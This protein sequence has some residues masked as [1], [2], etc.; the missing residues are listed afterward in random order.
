MNDS[1]LESSV[2]G[3]ESK[4]PSPRASSVFS[5][6][7]DKLA[8]TPVKISHGYNLL[9]H[10]REATDNITLNNLRVL[11][12]LNFAP[13][14]TIISSLFNRKWFIMATGNGNIYWVNLIWIEKLNQN[15]V[16]VY[17]YIMF[18]FV[19]DQCQEMPYTKDDPINLCSVTTSYLYA[20]LIA[21]GVIVFGL[22]FHFIHILQLAKLGC[23]RKADLIKGLAALRVPYLIL[24]CYISSFIYWIFASASL[25]NTNY[26]IPIPLLGRIGTSMQLYVWGTFGFAFLF[27]WFR[28]VFKRAFKRTL[29]NHLLDAEKK[30]LDALEVLDQ[31]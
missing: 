11:F 31:I 16:S 1:L 29:V 25:I 8:L 24:F 2:Q 12:I 10:K 20:G 22:L 7:D 18:L 9:K 26:E 15:L 6:E 13:F 28:W 27:L 17:H 19:Q 4:S 5:E 21:A 30:Y 14:A 3:G 23:R